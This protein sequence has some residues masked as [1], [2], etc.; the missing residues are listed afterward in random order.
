MKFVPFDVDANLR[1]TTQHG[2][3]DFPI[4]V[5]LRRM[6]KKEEGPAPLHWHDEIQFVVPRSG[7]ILFTVCDQEYRLT[8]N[9]YLF[10]N[11]KRLHMSKPLKKTGGDYIC[12]DIHPRFLYG[13]S[14]SLVNR[15]YVQPFLSSDA[16]SSILLDNSAPWH[17]K[18]KAL[19]DNLI[20]V[21]E[22]AEYAYEI[23]VQKIVLELWLL[24]INNSQKLS[25]K[26]KPLSQTEQ[27]RLDNILDFI[28]L[29][30]AD[31]ITLPD[32][33]DAGILSTGECC[34]FMKRTVGISPMTYLN[35][36]RIAKSVNLLQSTTLS[37]TE[38]AQTV[39]FESSSYYTERFKK[40][41]NCKP[42]EYRQRFTSDHSKD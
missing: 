28:K 3:Y 30:Y 32:I 24:I 1:E 29:H 16:L 12:I 4:A 21:Y 35:N 19:L 11:S 14:S 34:R 7:S 2:E 40:L 36:F 9:E 15:K 33:A 39:G 27:I 6:N 5:Y 26:A 8:P 20:N 22:T 25:V 41:M 42:L 23:T 17:S 13:Y 37:I 10:I 18:A 38:V 31:K